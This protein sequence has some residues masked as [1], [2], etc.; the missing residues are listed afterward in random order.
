MEPEVVTFVT[1]Y[2]HESGSHESGPPIKATAWV[3]AEEKLEVLRQFGMVHPN[4]K[5]V[6]R[7]YNERPGSLEV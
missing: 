6:G 3:E 4:C 7:A 2:L 5:V 1:S